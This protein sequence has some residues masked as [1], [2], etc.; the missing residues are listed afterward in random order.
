MGAGFE[1]TCTAA[2]AVAGSFAASAAGPG[3]TNA[4]IPTTAVTS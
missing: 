3:P 1:V 4:R 2:V